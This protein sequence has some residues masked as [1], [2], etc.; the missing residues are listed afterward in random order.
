MPLDAIINLSYEFYLALFLFIMIVG[1]GGYFLYRELTR[2]EERFYSFESEEN[3]DNLGAKLNIVIKLNAPNGFRDGGKAKISDCKIL[4][5]K[6]INPVKF[7]EK[8]NE[9]PTLLPLKGEA[10]PSSKFINIFN[11]KSRK[12]KEIELTQSLELGMDI[13][14]IENGKPKPT[15]KYSF[16]RKE[17]DV[18]GNW[19][20][21]FIIG[22]VAIISLAFTA[23]SGLESF[24]NLL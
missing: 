3:Y 2:S 19:K 14:T 13:S 11:P 6:D 22:M 16:R 4:T 23:V 24:L 21:L 17:V 18:K 10:A 1:I 12:E 9:F 5:K 20:N 15:N 8:N 7:L